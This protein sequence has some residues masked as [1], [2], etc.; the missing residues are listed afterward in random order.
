M[1]KSPTLC[2]SLNHANHATFLGHKL[3]LRREKL[4]FFLS[5]YKLIYHILYVLCEKIVLDNYNQLVVK[6]E[7]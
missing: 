4:Q 7:K 1:L 5:V 3:S 6:S 2:V